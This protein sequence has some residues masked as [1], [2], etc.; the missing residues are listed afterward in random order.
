LGA[1]VTDR[2]VSGRREAGA[3][4]GRLAVGCENRAVFCPDALGSGLAVVIRGA[5][6]GCGRRDGEGLSRLRLS[7]RGVLAVALAS[8]TASERVRTSTFPLCSCCRR[9]ISGGG[10]RDWVGSF[11]R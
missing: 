2:A 5:V 1:G 4:G 8:F 9:V 3:S 7:I 6:E 10:T 11:G